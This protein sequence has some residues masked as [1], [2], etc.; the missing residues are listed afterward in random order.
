MEVCT[1][2]RDL[3]SYTI[4]ITANEKIFL[5]QFQRALTDSI[6]ETDGFLKFE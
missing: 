5:P 6:N 4:Q 1:K 2:A 3:A